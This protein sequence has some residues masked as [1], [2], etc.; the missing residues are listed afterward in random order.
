[1]S[2][3]PKTSIDN[4]IDFNGFSGRIIRG[5]LSKKEIKLN[6]CRFG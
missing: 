4:V 3:L 6:K 5:G 2:A 1:M